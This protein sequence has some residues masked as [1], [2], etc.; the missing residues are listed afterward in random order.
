M[1]DQ[2]LEQARRRFEAAQKLGDR[3]LIMT[4]SELAAKKAL[5]DANATDDS[6]AAFAFRQGMQV[7][8]PRYGRGVVTEMSG[9]SH[10]ATVTVQFENDGEVQTFV[11]SRCP[12]QPIGL[13]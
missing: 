9:G 1:L 10:R 4:A 2:R 12:L 13:K 8:H 5:P 7:R 11:A 6:Q 3:K